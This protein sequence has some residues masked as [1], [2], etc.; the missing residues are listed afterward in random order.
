LIKNKIIDLFF[1]ETD[2]TSLH[3]Y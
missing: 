1:K 3:T 2:L